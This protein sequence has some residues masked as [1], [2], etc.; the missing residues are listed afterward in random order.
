M[1]SFSVFKP[2]RP[3]TNHGIHWWRIDNC[4]YLLAVLWS[5]TALTLHYSYLADAFIQ[6]NL[7]LIKQGTIPPQQCGVMGRSS[8]TAVWILLWL[9]W[10]LNHWPSWSQSYTLAARLHAAHT[11]LGWRHPLIIMSIIIFLIS[12]ILSD[13]W[14]W[15]PCK[16]WSSFN[17]QCII[18]VPISLSLNLIR[19]WLLINIEGFCHESWISLQT[20]LCWIL[21]TLFKFAEQTR[22]CC[23]S[24]VN[25]LVETKLSH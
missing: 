4:W 6:S 1:S 14:S 24:A 15:F 12:N 10:D 17:H 23:S 22:P 19:K 9:H 2:E 16:K 20:C 11:I 8:P 7:Q 13:W 5:I 3:S 21:L 18:P 25:C